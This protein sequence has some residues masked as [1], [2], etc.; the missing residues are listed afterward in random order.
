MSG[1]ATVFRMLDQHAADRGQ[2]P[3]LLFG[4]ETTTYAEMATRG[5]EQRPLAFLWIALQLE[6][7]R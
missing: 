5:E 1:P 4:G 3:F 2:H 7:W 6:C